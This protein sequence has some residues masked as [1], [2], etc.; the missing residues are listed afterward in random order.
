MTLFNLNRIAIAAVFAGVLGGCA[1]LAPLPAPTGLD[2]RLAALPVAELP[3]EAP[4]T[5]HWDD[6]Q[7]PF[8]VA[9][10][11]R[12][13]AFAL[14]LVHAHLRLGQMEVLRRISAGRLAEMGG[15]IATDIDHAL[16]ILDYG[17]VAPAVVAAMPPDSRAWVDA[18]VAGINHVQAVADP[19]PHEFDLLGFEREPW[20]PEDVVRL[21]RLA[22]TD[23]TWLVWFRLLAL[24]DRPDWP[25]VW[26]R[27]I[28]EGMTSAPSFAVAGDHGGADGSEAERRAAL[29]QLWVAT[30]RFGSNSVAVAGRRSASGS[31]LIA[32]DPHLGLALP[33]LWV[34]VGVKSPSYHMVGFSVPGLP[35]VAVGRNPWIGWG[36]TNMRAASSDLFDVTDLPADQVVT[37]TERIGVRW[38][39]DREVTVRDTAYGPIISDAPMLTPDDGEAWA[40]SWIGHR[41]SDE[42]TAMLRLNRARTWSEFRNALNGFALS[43]QNF[44]YADVEGNIGQ[45]T[46]TRLPRRPNVPPA[47]LI[48]P[49]EDAAAW[50]RI[51]T[52]REL[53]AVFNPPA[54]VVASANNRPT[55]DVDLPIG[56]FFSSDD[57]ILR[58]QELLAAR[59]RLSLD[60]LRR[61]QLDTVQLSSLRLRDALVAR[62]GALDPPPPRNAASRRVLDRIIGWD[63]AY[64]P[65][66]EGAVAFEAMLATLLPLLYDES[67]RAAYA[68]VGRP[69]SL[70]ADDLPGISDDRLGTAVAEALAAAAAAT[71][72]APRWGDL[73]RLGV[74]HLLG[75]VPV[76]GDWYHYGDLPTGGSRDTIWKTGHVITDQRHEVGFGANSRHLSDMGDPDANWFVLLGGQDGWLNSETFRDQVALFQTGRS[77]RVPLTVAAVERSFARRTVLTPAAR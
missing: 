68:A 41:P 27:M 9:E 52:A 13:A 38:W 15:P 53:P 40:L 24:R 10:T 65:A 11:D 14:G 22:S 56:Y 46:A 2:Q 75:R 76:I 43:P 16:R 61:L 51:V 8:I 25:K 67:D 54:G 37:R 73:H 39:F 26:A 4:V 44:V 23:V 30:G 48:R 19:L 66:S 42:L 50:T 57:R 60:D 71:A 17:R 21:G 6:H 20:R 31:A 72:D 34:I 64:T 59:P 63:G 7:I 47:D 29:E 55:S 12:D 77:I 33:N 1:L 35:F 45:V 49:R 58:L 36:G 62:I 3:L 28:E 18:Y 69:Y 74:T 32:N 5:V 70:V